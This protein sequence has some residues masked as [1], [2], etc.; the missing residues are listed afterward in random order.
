MGG[1]FAGLGLA[2]KFAGGFTGEGDGAAGDGLP[3]ADCVKGSGVLQLAMPKVLHTA[4][5]ICCAFG[6]PFLCRDHSI[7]PYW[8]LV[9][10]LLT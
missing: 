3:H 6:Q 1:G 8:A 10:L 9:L 5:V 7:M 2:G 4:E